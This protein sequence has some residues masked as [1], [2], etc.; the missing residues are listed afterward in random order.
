[1]TSDLRNL[2][3]PNEYVELIQ[4]HHLDMGPNIQSI[5]PVKGPA[6]QIDLTDTSQRYYWDHF[7]S[8]IKKYMSDEV[9]RITEIKQKHNRIT[10]NEFDQFCNLERWVDSVRQEIESQTEI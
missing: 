10:D 5:V 2:K 3:I 1:M 7:E 4:R 9:D 8:D 6:L